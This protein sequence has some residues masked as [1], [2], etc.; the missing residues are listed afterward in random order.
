MVGRPPIGERAM[1]PVERQRRRRA[2]L[3]EAV[4][5]EQVLAALASDYNRAHASEQKAIRAGVKRM[6]ARWQKDTAAT[7]RRTK[8]VR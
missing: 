5:P 6:L 3:A 7:P 2:K 4:C 8:R 1:T